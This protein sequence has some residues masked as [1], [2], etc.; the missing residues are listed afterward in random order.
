MILSGIYRIKNIVTGE[1]YVGS[2]KNI[3]RRWKYHLWSLKN[4]KHTN[5]ILQRVYNK[6]GKDIFKF[7]I[8]EICPVD[9]ILEREQERLDSKAYVY[10]IC[11]SATSPTLGRKLSEEHKAKISAAAKGHTR[12]LGQKRSAEQKA[13]MSAAAMGKPATNKG[14]KFSA[15]H[16]EKMVA[17]MKAAWARRRASK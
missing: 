9:L 8:L 7:E 3:D 12:C 17:G 5:A 16:K 10:N 4:N 11:L 2:A 14:K 13:H 6:H 1:A 15:E